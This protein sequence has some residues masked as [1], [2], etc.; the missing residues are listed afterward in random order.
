[1][2]IDSKLLDSLLVDHKQPED[3]GGENGLLTQFTKALEKRALQAEGPAYGMSR[4]LIIDFRHMVV[5]G[6]SREQ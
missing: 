2:T 6:Y 5:P 4:D 3:L 1:M